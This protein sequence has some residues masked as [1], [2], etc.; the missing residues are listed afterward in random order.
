[1]KNTL[2]SQSKQ[3]NVFDAKLINRLKSIKYKFYLKE[4]L[5][6]IFLIMKFN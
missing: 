6:N 5:E 2:A 1:M 3:K 4:K